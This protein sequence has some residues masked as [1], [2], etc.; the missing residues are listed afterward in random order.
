MK[1]R[2]ALLLVALLPVNLPALDLTP[3]SG[4]RDLEGFKIPI[5]HFTDAGKKI[6]FQPPAKWTISGGGATLSLYP[7]ATTDAMMQLRVRPFKPLPQG[8]TEDLEKWCRAQ[9]PQDALQPK[10]EG[11]VVQNV[12]MLDSRSSRQ[13]TYSYASQGRRFTTSVTVVDWSPTERLAVLVTARSTDFPGI[14]SAAMGSMFSWGM[15]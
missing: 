14:S 10:L 1:R 15:E 4:T 11:E 6:I 8:E 5:V 9:L 13:F 7:A 12:F 3:E 2:L